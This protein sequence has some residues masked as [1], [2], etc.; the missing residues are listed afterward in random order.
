MNEETKHERIARGI[1]D[2]LHKDELTY[3]EAL[4]ILEVVKAYY[5]TRIC[6]LNITP[7]AILLKVNE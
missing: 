7:D 2:L 3:Y 4:G 5:V 1:H 6:Q